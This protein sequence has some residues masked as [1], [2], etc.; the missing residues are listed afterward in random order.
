MEKNP[1]TYQ[2]F[3]DLKQSVLYFVSMFRRF[4]AWELHMKAASEREWW[5]NPRAFSQA[6]Y[7]WWGCKSRCTSGSAARMIDMDRWQHLSENFPG[8]PI[9][10]TARYCS[11]FLC[12]VYMESTIAFKSTQ[13]TVL[14]LASW[15]APSGGRGFPVHAFHRRLLL[16]YT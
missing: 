8:S 13:L 5:I 1:T 12:E 15:S 3:F 4:L 16:G 10:G 7:N 2:L 11:D 9:S 6:R 14:G